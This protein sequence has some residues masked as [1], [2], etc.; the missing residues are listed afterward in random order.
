MN[1]SLWSLNLI[2]KNLISVLQLTESSVDLIIL[3]HKKLGFV[4]VDTLCLSIDAIKLP[5]EKMVLRGENE[6]LWNCEVVVIFITIMSL[7]EGM[8]QQQQ[9]SFLSFMTIVKI[10]NLDLLYIRKGKIDIINCLQYIII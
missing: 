10:R 4:K 8:L 9:I 5:G 3:P 7:E 2:F 6:I 1:L